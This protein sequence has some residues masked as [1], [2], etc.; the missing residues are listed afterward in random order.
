MWKLEMRGARG[1][2]FT[3]LGSYA[4]INDAARRVLQTENNPLGAIFFRVYA[5]PAG[6]LFPTDKDV[7]SRLD[8]QS[9]TRYYVLS[10]TAQ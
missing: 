4:S 10:R 7:L 9:D 5:D 6:V 8:Y 3:D 1:T 2:P